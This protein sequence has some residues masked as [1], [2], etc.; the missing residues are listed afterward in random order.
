MYAM[1]RVVHIPVVQLILLSLISLP[2]KAKLIKV[3]IPM[4]VVMVTPLSWVIINPLS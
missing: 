4:A 2:P 3:T 1:A